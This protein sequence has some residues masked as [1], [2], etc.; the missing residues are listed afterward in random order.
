[1]YI[2]FKN[3]FRIKSDSLQ[4]IVEKKKI[5]Q[6]GANTKEAN[7]GSITWGHV[8]FCPTLDFALRAVGR[9]LCLDIDGLQDIKKAINS[10]EKEITAMT[11]LLQVEVNFENDEER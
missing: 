2:E 10:L 6:A 7:I 9:Q 1:M 5:I 3:G 11:E 8:A 4:F